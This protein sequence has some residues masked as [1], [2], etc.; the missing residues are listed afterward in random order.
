MVKKYYTLEQQDS[1]ECLMY[2]LDALH[3]GLAYE[4][5]V[6]IKGEV[7]NK[8]DELMK[9]SLETWKTFYEKEYSFILEMFN[10]M[11][12]NSTTCNGCTKNRVQSFEPYN[13]LSINLTPSDNTLHSI[14]QQH[15]IENETVQDWECKKCNDNSG[16]SKTTKLWA[17]PNYLVI[18]LK[19]FNNQ[20]KKINCNVTFPLTDLDLTEFIASEKGDPNKYLY[21]LYA[22]NCHSGTLNSGHYWSFCKNL[23]DNWYL[24]ND[25][26]VVKINNLSELQTKDAYILFY[27]RKYLKTD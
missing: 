23:D 18:H 20:G 4:I 27:Y 19:R 22:V 14:L 16:C 15:F 24:F 9:M 26:D 11:Y 1:H 8:T 25:S 13:S 10:G 7:K 21:T 3:R 6:D 12:L 5:D 17:M 2:I